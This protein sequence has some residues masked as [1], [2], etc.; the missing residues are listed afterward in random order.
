MPDTLKGEAV[1]AWIVLRAGQQATEDEL[2]KHCRETLSAFK[3]PSA[4]EFRTELPKSLIG[5][6][7]RRELVRQHVDAA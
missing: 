2:R 4:I 7:L 3:V 1:K 6:V 5:K